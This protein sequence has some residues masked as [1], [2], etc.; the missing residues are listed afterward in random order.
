MSLLGIGICGLSLVIYISLSR[1]SNHRWKYRTSD[2]ETKL[3]DYFVNGKPISWEKQQQEIGQFY[4]IDFGKEWKVM[5]IKFDCGETCK[6][7][8]KARF[9]FFS[10]SGGL[11]FPKG[12]RHPYVD[13]NTKTPGMG[14]PTIVRL[15]QPIKARKV[16]MEIIKPEPIQSW[17]VQAILVKVRIL[18][19]LKEH[20]IGDSSLDALQI[21]PIR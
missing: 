5:V 3:E 11:L 19:G 7:P 20:I 6:A 16:K 2:D 9:W 10:K 8:I 13:S 15:P 17:R 1:L 12:N 14:S 18:A 4:E 21:L